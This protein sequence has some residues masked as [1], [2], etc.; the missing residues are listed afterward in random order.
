MSV[1]IRLRRDGTKGKPFYHI[2]ATDSRKARNGKYLEKL[3]YY[4]PS[5]SPSLINIKSDRAQYW[6]GV[7]AQVSPRVAQLLKIEKV[8]LLRGK[9]HVD[10]R[11]PKA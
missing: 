8:P 1:T 5:K 10:Q 7:G 4:D 9:T 3:G 6:Y 11:I 2:I